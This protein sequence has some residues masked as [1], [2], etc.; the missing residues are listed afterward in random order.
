MLHTPLQRAVINLK[1][2]LF[3]KPIIEE[4]DSI[5]QRLPRSVDVGWVRDGKYIVGEIKDG[6]QT[7]VVQARSADEFIQMVNETILAV[8][9]VR[10]PYIKAI[11]KE[12]YPYANREA[13]KRLRKELGDESIEGSDFSLRKKQLKA[14]TVGS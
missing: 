9:N 4:V 11:L 12:S 7:Y 8:Y 13:E 1:E 3:F 10:L 14:Q 5:A 2:R 6:D